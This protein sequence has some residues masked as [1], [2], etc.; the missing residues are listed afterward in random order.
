MTLKQ[1]LRDDLTAAIKERDELRTS[2]LRMALAAGG[3]PC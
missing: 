2:T 1:R 3:T